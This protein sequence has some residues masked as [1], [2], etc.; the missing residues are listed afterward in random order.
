MGA[1]SLVKYMM[2]AHFVVP[3]FCIYSSELKLRRGQRRDAGRD[4][5]LVRNFPGDTSF[6]PFSTISPTFKKSFF[7]RA[8]HNYNFLRQTIDL[9]AYSFRDLRRVLSWFEYDLGG[10]ILA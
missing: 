9:D 1:V 3:N 2:C 7:Y 5:V 10:L 4:L 8:V 6:K